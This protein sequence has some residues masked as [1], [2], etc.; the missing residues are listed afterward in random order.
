MA[1]L[2]NAKEPG[3]LVRL[4]VTPRWWKQTKSSKKAMAMGQCFDSA[5]KYLA[6]GMG[7]IHAS[8]ELLVLDVF[9]PVDTSLAV[10]QEKRRCMIE[11]FEGFAPKEESP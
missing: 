10:L 6:P 4:D 9:V 1:T 3:V 5:W 2:S 11:V 8:W 7:E